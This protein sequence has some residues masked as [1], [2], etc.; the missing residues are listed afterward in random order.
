MKIIINNYCPSFFISPRTVKRWAD[1]VALKDARSIYIHCVGQQRMATVY[2][3]SFGVRKATDVLSF[4]MDIQHRL[5][6]ALCANVKT[7]SIEESILGEIFLC[8]PKIIKDSKRYGVPLE[9]R[10]AHL[11]IHSILHLLGYVHNS[12]RSAKSMESREI[13]M[14]ATLGIPNPY[15][16]HA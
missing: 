4:Q 11:I 14:L 9:N 1:S 5:P 15:L 7:T 10:L 13:A 16:L 6:K 8:I 12:E 2:H 3:S